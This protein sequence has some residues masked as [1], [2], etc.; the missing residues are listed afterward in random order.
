MWTKLTL[1]TILDGS[2]NALWNH[3]AGAANIRTQW[4]HPEVATIALSY[5]LP[6]LIL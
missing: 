6:N 2:P 5:G 1:F 4:T 3:G